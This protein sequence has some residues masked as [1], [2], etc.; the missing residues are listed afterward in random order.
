M[1][2]RVRVRVSVGETWLL[3]FIR[4][5]RIIRVLRVSRVTRGIRVIQVMR[6]ICKPCRVRRSPGRKNIQS[7]PQPLP[8]HPL[9]TC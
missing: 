3:K 7:P 5:I 2:V 6:I 9:A 4:V 8:M 1:T